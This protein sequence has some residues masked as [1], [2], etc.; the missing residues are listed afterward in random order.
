[1]PCALAA[2]ASFIICARTDADARKADRTKAYA[3]TRN[4]EVTRLEVWNAKLKKF[5]TTSLVC[6]AISGKSRKI[7]KDRSKIVERS[8]KIMAKS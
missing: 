6:D 4:E 7:V 1:M 8:C 3:R 2:P 5:V